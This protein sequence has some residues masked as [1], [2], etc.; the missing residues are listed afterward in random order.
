MSVNIDKET[1]SKQIITTLEL[2]NT[3]YGNMNDQK[4][5]LLSSDYLQRLCPVMDC[6]K[7]KMS[8]LQ[9]K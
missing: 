6:S 9:N 4:G 5:T 1:I 3:S 7:L 8:E 2:P